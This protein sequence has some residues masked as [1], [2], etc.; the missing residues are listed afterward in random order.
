MKLKFKISNE[1]LFLEDIFEWNI[2]NWNGLPHEKESE[3]FNLCGFSWKLILSPCGSDRKNEYVSLFLENFNALKYFNTDDNYKYIDAN[4]YNIN[5][6]TKFVL[7][8]RQCNNLSNYVAK[9]ILILII[10]II[11]ME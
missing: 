9:R 1:D 2:E 7:Y 11:I 10:I 6:P 8:I 5:V 3:I 4:Q